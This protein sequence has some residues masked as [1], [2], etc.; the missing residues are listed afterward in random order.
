MPLC[1]LCEQVTPWSLRAI[2]FNGANVA[3]PET[4]NPHHRS[5]LA[6]QDSSHEC[7]LCRLMCNSL[8][9][10][11]YNP[12]I[13]LQQDLP[14]LVGSVLDRYFDLQIDAPQVHNIVVQCGESFTVLHAFANPQSDAAMSHAVA[15]R[16]P[17]QPDSQEHFKMIA[18]W[19]EECKRN[20]P[21]CRIDRIGQKSKDAP[22]TKT[23][24][25][26]RRVVDVGICTDSTVRLFESPDS[27]GEYVALSHRWPTDPSKHYT[28]T[29]AT[30]K[31]RKRAM[32]LEDMPK[33]FQDAVTVSRE[34]GFRYLWIDSLCIIQD[35]PADWDQQSVLMGQ[36]YYRATITIM[37]ATTPIPSKKMYQEDSPE[38]FLYRIPEL[39]RLLTV[40]MDYYDEDW[41]MK[42]NWFIQY[43]Q[44]YI[45]NNLDL[46]T[47][48]W[49]LQEELLSRRKIIYAPDQVLWVSELMR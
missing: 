24:K 13:Q 30:I 29:R 20:H 16:L 10:N 43:R 9:D 2:R 17:L 48:G 19:L 6:L 28:T 14:I 44:Q 32:S 22:L 45:S 36:I 47:R 12:S 31:N 4:C 37:S 38:G 15:G 25:L 33:T 40:K 26:P 3:R 8:L 1:S 23:S 42:G 46:L 18:T 34:L 11:K 5:F 49:V 27:E 41:R 39:S 21:A 7:E 35:D